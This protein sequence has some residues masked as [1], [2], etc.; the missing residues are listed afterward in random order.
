MSGAI[1]GIAIAEASLRAI[2]VTM[3]AKDGQAFALALAGGI[4][5]LWPGCQSAAPPAALRDL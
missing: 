2:P 4:D 5:R 1:R 3:N